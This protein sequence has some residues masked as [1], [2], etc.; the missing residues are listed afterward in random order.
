MFNLPTFAHPEDKERPVSAPLFCWDIANPLLEK[1]IQ[2]HNDIQQIE[3]LVRTYD[4]QLNINFK[5]LLIDNHSIVVTNLSQEIVWVSQSFHSMTGYD[6]KEA[7]GK[8]P[9]FLQG[10]KTNLQ[11][12]LFIKE[13]L[14]KLESTE[15]KILNY[16]K[17]GESYWCGIRIF[18][19]QN[20]QS[21][22]THYI[23]IEKEVN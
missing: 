10:E 1:R 17:N 19:I 14:A 12:K 21:L 9:S 22:L 13:K 18:P 16:R 3:N 4:W 6:T 5:K 2:I 11:T 8:I 7:I 20:S 15:A 23:A